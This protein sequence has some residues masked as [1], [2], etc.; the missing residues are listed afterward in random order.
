MMRVLALALLGSVFLAWAGEPLYPTAEDLLAAARAREAELGPYVALG[1]FTFDLGGLGSWTVQFRFW[2]AYPLFRIELDMSELGLDVPFRRTAIVDAAARKRFQKLTE[3]LWL[4]DELEED[5][6]PMLSLVLPAEIDDWTWEVGEEEVNG[7]PAWRLTGVGAW[8]GWEVRV[9]Q[10]MEKETLV[11]LKT[12]AE[13][14]GMVFTQLVAEFRPE[15]ELPSDLFRLPPKARRLVLSPRSPEAEAIMNRVLQDLQGLSSFYSTVVERVGDSVTEVLLWYQEPYLLREERTVRLR[16]P[17]T[18]L[19]EIGRV[20]ISLW[21]MEHGVHYFQSGGKW[22]AVESGSVPPAVRG[23]AAVGQVFRLRSDRFVAVEEGEFEGRPVWVVTVEELQLHEDSTAEPLVRVR[24]WVDRETHR[25]LQYEEP[26]T[27]V[28]AGRRHRGVKV[29]RILE[30]RPGAE[31]PPEKIAVPAGVPVQKRP[32]PLE[33]LEQGV[34]W[35]P[36][37]TARWE[38]ARGKPVVLYFSAEW[39]EPCRVLEEQVF[40]D[41]RVV[42]ALGPFVRLKVDLSDWQDREARAA[43]AAHRASALPTLVFFDADGRE[44]GRIV[45]YSTRFVEE[46]LALVRGGKR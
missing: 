45:G 24:W 1:W 44:I 34:A 43:A 16:F 35:E 20:S 19:V 7:R 10:W 39:C 2:A 32:E 22:Q 41:S 14:G 17:G 40:R 30:F 36:Y 8:E 21:D 25:V 42:E 23:S 15:A 11:T 5:R 37:T 13:V 12:R 6:I 3:E 4:E 27:I 29:V 46:L 28:D 38:E 26:I 33:R 9:T 31:V 18:D